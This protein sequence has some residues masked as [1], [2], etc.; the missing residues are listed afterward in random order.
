MTP[1]EARLNLDATT[2][3]PQDT[4]E[5]ARALV[6]SDPALASW[7]EKRRQLD[8]QVASA[9]AGVPVPDDLRA[10]LLKLEHSAAVKS[11]AKR[12]LD[13]WLSTIAAMAVVAVGAVVLWDD[14]GHHR[15]MPEWQRESLAL[16]REIDSGSMPLDHFSSN[17]DEIRSLL[18]KDHRPVP[19][20]LP[21]GVEAM[22]S[23]GCK[24]VQVGPRQV[25]VVCFEIMP[26][27]EAH[28][29]VV[30]NA[31]GGLPGAPPQRRPEFVERDGW[32]VAR[33]SDGS[34][35]YFIATR[36]PRSALEKLFALV[37]R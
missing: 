7:D 2:L 18:V 25:T 24:S 12:R 35:C 8:E 26:G 10:K 29:V 36:A 4:A 20:G 3:R 31:E 21:K 11:P 34:Q 17:L 37:A 15:S 6:V 5:E 27:K 9:M 22:A 33:W 28:L 1:E 13:V 14:V 32:N 23:L 16:V 19:A 30:N